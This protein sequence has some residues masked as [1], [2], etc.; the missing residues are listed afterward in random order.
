MKLLT[1]SNPNP[2]N[3]FTYRNDLY[4]TALPP[5]TERSLQNLYEAVCQD[6]FFQM[7]PYDAD[8]R[9]LPSD[10]RTK[11]LVL[12]DDT[13]LQMGEQSDRFADFTPLKRKLLLALDGKG[14]VTILSAFKAVRK[15]Q[16]MDKTDR[17]SFLALIRRTDDD[18]G[19]KGYM[20]KLEGNTIELQVIPPR[21]S[22]SR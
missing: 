20:I 5:R 4:N 12:L 11:W 15:I 6:S 22:T 8:Y 13:L 21:P 10:R 3:S 19:K 1:P 7:L 14:K 2:I 9:P 18:V 17:A 16:R